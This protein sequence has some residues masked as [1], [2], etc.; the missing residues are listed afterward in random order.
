MSHV[1]PMSRVEQQLQEDNKNIDNIK[2]MIADFK[3]GNMDDMDLKLSE[4][5]YYGYANGYENG[6]ENGYKNALNGFVE[7]VS[8]L[9]SSLS[10][11]Q[12]NST[13]ST[14][15]DQANSTASTSKDQANSTAS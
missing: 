14:S 2:N 3:N 10:K 8:A 9:L 5:Y 6:Y 11:D 13:A 4:A 12:A 15:K 7:R 1:E